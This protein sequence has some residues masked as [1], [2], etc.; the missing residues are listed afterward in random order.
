MRPVAA[1]QVCDHGAGVHEI[2]LL[3]KE[4]AAAQYGRFT[5]AQLAAAVPGAHNLITT[6][7]RS[8]RWRRETSRVL[9]LPGSP[10]DRLG[11]IWAAH[12]HVGVDSVV[13]GRSAA[14]L[15]GL[16]GVGE[17][18]P[19]LLVPNG[20][21]RRAQGVW[22]RQ[23]TDLD[24]S[25][26]TRVA[27][28]PCTSITRTFVELSSEVSPSRLDHLLD[29]ATMARQVV[30]QD[31]GEMVQSLRRRGRSGLGSVSRVVGRRLPGPGVEQGR[32]ER[33]LTRVVLMAGIGAGVAQHPHPGR[34][35]SAERVDRAFPE[36]MLL[37]EAD[38]RSWHARYSAM[39]ADRR[40]DREAARAGWLTVR[41]TWED[42]H[43]HPEHSAGELG[44]IHL[45][46][47]LLLGGARD[48][49]PADCSSDS[50]RPVPK[51][52]TG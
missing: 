19:T 24:P 38:G 32:L 29:E 50:S 27:G 23:V 33:E 52:R 12:L 11:R 40:R 36:A 9:R 34:V 45:R 22:I 4:L 46:R 13:G 21:H 31:L 43:R 17:H 1:G 7:L 2:D 6:R 47:R 25:H 3:A 37:V 26:V 18:E 44:E 49:A 14:L 39:K 28:L 16:T 35:D 5:R 20:S 48:P 41:F 15:H 30:P 42:L 51:S 10:E 8:G